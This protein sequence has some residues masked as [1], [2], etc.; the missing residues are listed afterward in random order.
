MVARPL[1][2]K[3]IRVPALLL[4]L[5]LF[6]MTSP[7]AWAT[8]GDWL[9]HEAAA[10][11]GAATGPVSGVASFA[12]WTL[13]GGTPGS[14][15][16]LGLALASNDATRGPGQ[17]IRR[18][19]GDAPARRPWAPCSGPGCRRS[20]SGP[21]AAPVARTLRVAEPAACSQVTASPI[22]LSGGIW[23]LVS[24]ENVAREGFPLLLFR[25]P[26]V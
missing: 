7:R 18:F 26:C 22:D 5:V 1:L 9:Q 13:E 14:G 10:L 8:C 20:E 25:P 4:A 21:Q 2:L 17:S 6:F 11:A 19:A 16:L 24:Q 12:G 15:D 3:R 23:S